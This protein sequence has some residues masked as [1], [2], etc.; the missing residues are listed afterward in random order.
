MPET[1][2][3]KELVEATGAYRLPALNVDDKFDIRTSFDISDRG[4]RIKVLEILDGDT[5]QF[6]DVIG[7]E[8]ELTDFI[9]HPVTLTNRETGEEFAAVR[10]ILIAADGQAVSTCSPYVLQSLSRIG[11]AH[12]NMPPWEPGIRV[13]LVQQSTKGKKRVFK[14]RAVKS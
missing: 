13:K 11:W 10:T 4:N 12:G 5:L 8:L 6:E 7:C 3:A 2:P 14:L 9:C 1:L